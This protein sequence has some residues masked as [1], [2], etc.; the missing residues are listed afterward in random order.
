MS[1]FGAFV[2]GLFGAREVQPRPSPQP[3][4]SGQSALL[5]RLSNSPAAQQGWLMGQILGLAKDGEIEDL[6]DLV[7]ENLDDPS[8]QG[9]YEQARKTYPTLTPWEIVTSVPDPNDP[10]VDIRLDQISP[11]ERRAILA[12]YNEE[13]PPTT[14]PMASP[15]PGGAGR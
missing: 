13:D 2:R 6:K 3:T 1:S 5:Q 9:L 10:D 4:D 15:H 8:L 7:L 14:G 11:E 12:W